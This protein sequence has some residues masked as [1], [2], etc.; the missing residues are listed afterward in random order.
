M[1]LRTAESPDDAIDATS[2]TVRKDDATTVTIIRHL[3]GA[4][5]QDAVEAL[6]A[7]RRLRVLGEVLR[8]VAVPDRAHEL[9]AR[10]R[11]D[12]RHDVLRRGAERARHPLAADAVLHEREHEVLDRAGAGG[13]VL[14][15]EL[16]GQVVLGG[17]GDDE[18]LRHALRGLA[19]LRRAVQDYLAGGARKEDIVKKYGEINNWDVSKVTRMSYMF[20][21]AES[22][23]QP[24]NK[25]D[26]SSVTSM[27]RMFLNATSFNQPLNNWN[28]SNVKYMG[29]MFQGA[30]SFNQ[31][32]NKWNVSKVTHMFEL[33]CS[34]SSFNQPLDNW[35]VSNVEYMGGMFKGAESFNQ[36]L[37]KWNVSKVTYMTGMFA[38]AS[39]FNQ[40]LN[41]WNVSNVEDMT[42]MFAFAS[43]FNHSNIVAFA[44]LKYTSTFKI[45][46]I[47]ISAMVQQLFC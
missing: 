18:P 17:A 6:L 42:G 44:F 3:L 46:Y 10:G 8:R 24:L 15:A 29:A 5:R 32:L 21:D 31:P 37:N 20:E 27:Y 40:P 11:A 35:D 13:V 47:Y 23:N 9:L 36:P 34:A 43:S 26:V 16:L 12:G 45:S 1:G 39:S 4:R 22:F 41:N 19:F 2:R 7:R 33:F 30:R 38:S 28:V 14:E 25:W